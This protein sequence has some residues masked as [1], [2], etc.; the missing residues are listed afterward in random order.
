[1]ATLYEMTAQASQLYELLQADEIDEQIF[2][3]T[4]EAM[5]TAEKIESYCQIIKQ[6]QADADMFKGEIDRMNA[7]K[8][9]AENGADRMKAALLAFLQQSGQDKV[10]A[11]SFA[12]STATTQAVSITDESKLPPEYLIAQPAKV[13]KAGIKKALKD[14]ATIAGAELIN[15]TGVRI[16]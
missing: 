9:S 2:A 10:K 8:K 6:L 1:M 7:R 12:V 3:D 15:N 5:G 16:R 13:D 4:L 11:G 14:G